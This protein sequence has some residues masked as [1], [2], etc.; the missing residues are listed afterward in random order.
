MGWVWSL[1]FGEL[2]EIGIGLVFEFEFG[3]VVGEGVFR[4]GFGGF[5][6]WILIEFMGELIE[7]MHDGEFWYFL[8]LLESFFLVVIV[9]EIETVLGFVGVE[10]S[11]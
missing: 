7:V 2:V 4:W 3:V 1:I 8:G 11:Q 6:R 9:I 5:I 10:V